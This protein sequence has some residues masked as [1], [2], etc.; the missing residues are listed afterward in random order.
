LAVLLP[1]VFLQAL[2]IVRN[3]GNRVNQFTMAHFDMAQHYGLLNN[4]VGRSTSN[5]RQGYTFAG[6]Q[7]IMIALLARVISWCLEEGSD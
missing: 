2:A 7:E 3:P 6:H 1:E 5:G 4:V